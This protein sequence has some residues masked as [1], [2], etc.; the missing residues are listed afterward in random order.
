MITQLQQPASAHRHTVWGFSPM[1]L[2]DRFWAARG[3][4][5]VRQGEAAELVG[6]A[7]LFLLTDASLLT[8]FRLGHLVDTLRWLKPQL[9]FLRLRSDQ[10]HGYRERVIADHQNRFLRFE[11]VYGGSDSRVTR[12][13]L[14]PNR[15]LAQL[16]QTPAASPAAA[17]RRLRHSVDRNQRTTVSID[18]HAFDDASDH[19][20]VNFIRELVQI[21]KRPN[22][23]IRRAQPALQQVWADPDTVIGPATRFIGPVWV[24]AGRHLAGIDSVVGPAVL[25]DDPQA[26]PEI[27]HL[28]WQDIEL[29]TGAI[30]HGPARGFTRPIHPRRLSLLQRAGKRTFDILFSLIA[31]ALA[32]PIFPLVILAILLEDGPPF[33]FAHRRETAGGRQFP[34]LKFRTMRKDAEQLKSQLVSAN[35]ADGPQFY[36]QDDPRMTRVGRFIRRLNLDELPQFFNVLLGHMSVVGPRPSPYS[37]NQYCPPWREA[38]LS[39]RPGITGLWQVRRSR[40]QGKDFQEWIRY[41]I[42]YVESLNWRLDLQIILHT[43]LEIIGHRPRA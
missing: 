40:Q 31:L 41:D 7:D 30:D 18:G 3:V 5:V 17:W 28:Q 25:W 13:A 8:I 26:R 38:R 32:L 43:V 9:L 22:T 33:F 14:T 11:R 19:Q 34:C 29:P 4:Q 12:V 1:Q 23:T 37:E 35:Q 24:G 42:E 36:I 20:A 27:D 16:W 2:H 6:H 15:Q 39:V 10:E 21:W